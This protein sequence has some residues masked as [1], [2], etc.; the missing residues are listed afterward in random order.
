M[1]S[2]KKNSKKTLIEIDSLYK[3]VISQLPNPDRINYCES[4]MY[5]SKNDL[6]STKCRIK[7]RKLKRLIKATT[8]E[9][10]KLENNFN[11]YVCLVITNL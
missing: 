2:F 8:Y 5:R 9:I 6:V 1:F 7:R 4:L 11:M 3:K 10:K